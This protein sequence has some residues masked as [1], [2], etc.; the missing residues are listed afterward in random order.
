MGNSLAEQQKQALE[1]ITSQLMQ[2]LN[3]SIAQADQTTRAAGAS[4][5]RGCAFMAP[6]KTITPTPEK[7]PPDP[8][9]AS[10]E[11][12]ARIMNLPSEKS[13]YDYV[14]QGEIPTPLVVR[15]G[16][17]VQFRTELTREWIA[18]RVTLESASLTDTEAG[19]ARA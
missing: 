19:D 3:E 10:A 16:R 12:M 13:V 18:G 15:T 4:R 7:A 11:W 14:S 6:C 5:L 9:L 1:I 8:P 2:S 17:K